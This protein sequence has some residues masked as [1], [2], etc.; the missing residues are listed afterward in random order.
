MTITQQVQ[1]IPQ[2]MESLHCFIR[3]NALLSKETS[4]TLKWSMRDFS[5]R[6]KRLL[7]EIPDYLL[8]F[9][10]DADEF[11]AFRKEFKRGKLIE[12]HSYKNFEEFRDDTLKLTGIQIPNRDEVIAKV[13]E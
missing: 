6:R 12:K 11:V 5:Q 8:M 13:F 1:T 10:K 9:V 3:S 2:R 7:Y 4:T